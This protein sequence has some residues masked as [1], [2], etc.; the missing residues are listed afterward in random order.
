M[1][2]ATFPKIPSSYYLYGSA[3]VAMVVLLV[4][5]VADGVRSRVPSEYDG[6]AQCLTENGAK[7]YGAWWC[8]H[9]QNQKDL[10]EGAFRYV[11]YVE[12]SPGGSKTSSQECIDDGIKGFPTW[13]FADGSIAEGEQSL[14]RLSEITSCPLPDE[15]NQASE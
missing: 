14:Q 7:M 15:N 11:E 3:A 4:A 1:V 2:M 6:F 12:C 9:C 13:T 8:P 10:F 5:I